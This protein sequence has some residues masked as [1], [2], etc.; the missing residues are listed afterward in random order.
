MT[1]P[2]LLRDDYLDGRLSEPDAQRFETHAADC[3]ACD[4]ALLADNL[5]LGDGLGLAALADVTCPPEI[6]A[7]VLP[8]SR[9]AP[10]R[11]AAARP[12]ARRTRGRLWLAPLG[13]AVA[14]VAVFLMM[15]RDRAEPIASADDPT[16]II[17]PDSIQPELTDDGPEADEVAADAPLVD[18]AETAPTQA[19]PPRPA[20][21]PTPPRVPAR[22]SRS[23]S[24]P[25]Q[26]AE[27]PPPT[28]PEP[29]PEEI[30]AAARDLALAFAIVDDAQ[31]RAGR[32]VREEVADLS[33]T[34]D[35]AIPQ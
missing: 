34:L 3:D 1:D 32:T 23:D 35:Y 20:P 11:P 10:D 30:E 15:P 5:G 25:V 16:V 7:A 33:S 29:T 6:L 13:L 18:P 26:V 24:A 19:A 31:S 12:A 2:C 4:A 8:G 9:R 17:A 21:R 27:A 22:P 14:A 28:E